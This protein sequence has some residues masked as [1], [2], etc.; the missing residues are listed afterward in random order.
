MELELRDETPTFKKY[1]GIIFEAD[2]AEECMWV[3]LRV[4][5]VTNYNLRSASEALWRV[6]SAEVSTNLGE[7]FLCSVNRTCGSSGKILQTEI[8]I[9]NEHGNVKE[10]LLE[11]ANKEGVRKKRRISLGKSY[12]SVITNRPYE[13]LSEG[14]SSFAKIMDYMDKAE[15][16]INKGKPKRR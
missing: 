3:M 9:P 2:T 5:D 10:N 15:E 12:I 13:E 14:E 1:R 16:F 4:E 7:R 11:L 8:E 6:T